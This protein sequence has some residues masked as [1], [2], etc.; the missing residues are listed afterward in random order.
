MLGKSSLEVHREALLGAHGLVG[1]DWLRLDLNLEGDVV[2]QVLDLLIVVVLGVMPRH[3][4]HLGV[5]ALAPLVLVVVDVAVLVLA[6][7]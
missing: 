6:R 5:V 4:V 2:A 1:L 3:L 7:K